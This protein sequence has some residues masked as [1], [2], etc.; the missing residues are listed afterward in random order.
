[1]WKE[2]ITYTDF[3]DVE[4]TEDFYFNLSKAE[5]IKM[6]TDS[7]GDLSDELTRILDN[8]DKKGLMRYLYDIILKSYGE[9]SED[10]RRFVKV[11]DKG[12]SLGEEFEQSDAFSE[13]YIK[14]LDNDDALSNF[15]K[16]IMPKDLMSEVD[17]MSPEE[18][19]SLAKNKSDKNKSAKPSKKVKSLT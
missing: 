15:T 18:I 10:G 5:L 7:K 14:L 11:N 4:R 3:N 8:D 17:K 12:M 2:T 9:K 1:M 6:N 13:L 16:G 19:I